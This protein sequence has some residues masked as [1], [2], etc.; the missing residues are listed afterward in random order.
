VTYFDTITSHTVE[1]LD[2]DPNPNAR[3]IT[4]NFE[5]RAAPRFC[6]Y[7]SSDDIAVTV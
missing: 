1:V 3:E 2:G 6:S 7:L 4:A 5:F